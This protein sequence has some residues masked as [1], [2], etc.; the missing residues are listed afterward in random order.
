MA[1]LPNFDL[2]LNERQDQLSDQRQAHQ[3]EKRS[4]EFNANR[5]LNGYYVKFDKKSC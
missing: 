4:D 3:R 1:N 2:M 5:Q